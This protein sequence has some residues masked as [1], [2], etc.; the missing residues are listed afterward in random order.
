M[1]KRRSKKIRFFYNLR[2][3]FPY[4]KRAA[5]AELKSEVADSY[6]NWLWW[7]IEPLCYMLIYMFVFTVVFGTKEKYFASFVLI[8]QAVWQFFSRMITGSTTLITGNRGLVT[9]VYIPKYILLLSKSFTYLFK[10]GISLLLCFVIMIIQR[11]PLDWHMLFAP[12]AIAVIYVISFGLG[13]ILMH[14]GVILNDLKNLT[15][16][17]L[18]MLFYL[19]GIFW[20]IRTRL[21]G[22]GSL[23]KWLLICNP[24][25]FVMDS[26]R[27]CLIYG[28]MPSFK[29]LA[30]WLGI[31]LFLTFIGVRIIHKN[32]NTYAKVI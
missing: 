7:I 16:I 22:F 6:L 8:G 18:Q 28:E 4:A 31:G 17:G 12:L 13:L 20:N 23:W 9:K 19:S 29:W 30:I 2:K 15:N 1:P 5:K 32:E 11:V 25:A 24:A 14:L 27:K 10:F 3:Y 26:L 21:A